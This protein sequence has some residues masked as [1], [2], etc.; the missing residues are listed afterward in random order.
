VTKDVISQTIFSSETEDVA[1][2][3]DWIEVTVDATNQK[4]LTTTKNSCDR[5][6]RPI[7][8]NDKGISQSR[9]LEY[10]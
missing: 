3:M 2:Q 10:K 4:N 9:L 1:S 5:V 8:H 7:F 6:K